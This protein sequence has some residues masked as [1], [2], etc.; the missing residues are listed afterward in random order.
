MIQSVI[1]EYCFR[2]YT[3]KSESNVHCNAHQNGDRPTTGSTW[4]ERSETSDIASV[5]LPTVGPESSEISSSSGS[6]KGERSISCVLEV[7]LGGAAIRMLLLREADAMLAG[8]RLLGRYGGGASSRLRPS[9][10]GSRSTTVPC[11]LIPPAEVMDTRSEVSMPV[12]YAPL[13]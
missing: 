7:M 2:V 6:S 3:L 5:P 11:L 4:Y 13:L 8:G 10:K 1:E 9:A 12:K